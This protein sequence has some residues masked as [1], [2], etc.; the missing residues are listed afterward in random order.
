MKKYLLIAVSC[1]AMQ[2]AFSQE[3]AFHI[4]GSLN[5]GVP[6]SH[7]S[8]LTP[9]VSGRGAGLAGL[10]G[11]TDRFS[12]GLALDRQDFY[13]KYPRQVYHYAGSDISAVISN[14]IQTT[15]LVVKGKYLLTSSGTLVPY[16]TAGIGADFIHYSKYY[17]EFSDDN[18]AINFAGQAAFGAQL[19]LSP[20]HRTSLFLEAEYNFLPYSYK[21]AHGLSFVG[22]KAGI[23][24]S[25]Y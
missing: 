11:I 14:S 24:L 5:V 4:E 12:L 20:S 15:P 17:G 18:A 16:V 2:A 13:Q 3:G 7:L 6:L 8:E 10:Y 25:T 1:L 21:D 23:S 22:I 19:P 9:A